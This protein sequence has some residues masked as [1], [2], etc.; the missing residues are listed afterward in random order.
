[1]NIDIVRAYFVS[2]KQKID[3]IV[4]RLKMVEN[5]RKKAMRQMKKEGA[6]T[7]HEQLNADCIVIKYR[8]T[9]IIKVIS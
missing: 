6:E 4:L 7:M 1:M 8:T 9:L 2:F 3:I 5:R